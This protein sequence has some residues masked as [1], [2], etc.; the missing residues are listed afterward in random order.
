MGLGREE[1][2]LRLMADFPEVVVRFSPFSAGLLHCEVADFREATERAMGAG[3]LWEAERH[4]RL[5]AELLVGAGSEVRNALDV[6]YRQD[7]ALGE[8]TPV[9][10]QAIK[11]RMPKHLRQVLIRYHSHWQ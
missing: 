7:L 4:F 11:E 10:Y 9:R 8:F 1:F 3:E 2:L 6:C 5:V